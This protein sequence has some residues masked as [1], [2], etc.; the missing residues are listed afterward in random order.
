MTSR[1]RTLCL[2]H[3]AP[4]HP[5]TP[6]RRATHL[7]PSL[8]RR[9]R[10]G[11]REPRGRHVPLLHGRA[12]VAV[13]L[14]SQRESRPWEGAAPARG[15]RAT[16]SPV[17][18]P[19]RPFR[20]HSPGPRAQYTTFSY[21]WAAADHAVVDAAAWAAGTVAPP[22]YVVNVT[23]TGAVTSDVVALAFY[24]TGL[25]GEPLSEV[26]QRAR[27]HTRARAL[28][29]RLRPPSTPDR[30]SST[31]SARR[32]SRRAPRRP[33]TSRCPRRWPRPWRRTACRR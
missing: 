10:H 19:P 4:R 5:R 22:M 21:A 9:Q 14:G 17:S 26:R 12:A 13:R 15:A 1:L 32:R 11:P 25:P 16:C 28:P 33:S 7:A 3:R 2:A 8:A 27:A 24:S 31:S 23:N 20:D 29:D 6:R 18:A 30:S